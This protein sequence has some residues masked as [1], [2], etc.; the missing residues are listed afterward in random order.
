MVRIERRHG[1]TI[2]MEYRI[3]YLYRHAGENDPHDVGNVARGHDYMDVE[4]RVTSGTGTEEVRS[5]QHPVNNPPPS[6]LPP[7]RGKGILACARMT[8]QSIFGFNY[9]FL[10]VEIQVTYC[11]GDIE[12]GEQS[13][14]ASRNSSISSLLTSDAVLSVSLKYSSDNARKRS[15]R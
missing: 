13:L 10:M 5:D 8:M 14:M 15:I 9:R 7:V 6:Y 3:S 2:I 11:S 4:G 1:P 12:G